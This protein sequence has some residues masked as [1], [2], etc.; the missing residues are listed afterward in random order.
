MRI[1]LIA[2]SLLGIGVSAG[3][4]LLAE[5]IATRKTS[6]IEQASALARERLDREVASLVR[7]SLQHL[8]TNVL[9]KFILIASLFITHKLGWIDGRQFAMT[10]AILLGVFLIRDSVRLWPSTHAVVRHLHR[11]GWRPREAVSHYVSAR[12]FDTALAEIAEQNT[13]P[14]T[15]FLLRLAGTSHD[16]VSLEIAAAIATI[17]HETGYGQIRPRIIIA[18]THGAA[19]LALY[20]AIVFAIFRLI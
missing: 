18:C 16:Q 5:N 4:K 7:T 13:P 15:K 3:R 8:L 19:I 6:A 11:H 20:S 12:V 1:A 17:A 9:V 14:R 10:A 2:A